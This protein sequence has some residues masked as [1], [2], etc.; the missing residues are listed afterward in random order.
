[1]LPGQLDQ[2]AVRNPLDRPDDQVLNSHP[3][4]TLF[5]VSFQNSPAQDCEHLGVH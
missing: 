2:D 4:A 3:G 5:K 1:M